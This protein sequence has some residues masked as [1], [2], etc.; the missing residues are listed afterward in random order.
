MY[1][2][3]HRVRFRLLSYSLYT[4]SPTM[5]YSQETNRYIVF[6]DMKQTQDIELNCA[7]RPGALCERYSVEWVQQ[8][9]DTRLLSTTTFDITVNA[10]YSILAEYRCRVEIEHKL[11][12]RLLYNGPLIHL[13]T[14]GK[15][16]MIALCVK[17]NKLI[18]ITF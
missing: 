6:Q 7:I 13:Q 16:F 8:S 10:S 1:I 17:C 3:N 4:A 11:G 5:N 9:P 14:N 2:D 12:L 15:S 18:L